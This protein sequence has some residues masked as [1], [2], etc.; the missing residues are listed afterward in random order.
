MESYLIS[1]RLLDFLKKYEDL[2]ITKKQ[3]IAKGVSKVFSDFIYEGFVPDTW[4]IRDMERIDNRELVFHW[5][6]R[7]EQTACPA[8][9]TVSHYQVKIYDTRRI[10]DLPT[11]GMT[12]FHKVKANRYTCENPDCTANMFVEQFADIADKDAR[13][14]HRLKDLGV[15]MAVE[16]SCHGTSKKLEAMGAQVSA[17]TITREVKKKGAAVVA[18]NLKRDDVKVLSVDDINLRKG[19]A[20]TACSVFIDA[21]THRVLVIVQGASAD[22]A[23]KVIQQ[24]PSADTV[25]R[26]RGNAYRAAAT[27]YGKS[28]VADE[29]HLVQN[30]HQAVKEAL[31]LEIGQD[32]FVRKG[33][34]WIQMVDSAQEMP[35]PDSSHQDHDEGLIVIGPATLTEADIE[36]RIRLGCLTYRQAN[37]YKRTMEIL[38]LTESGLRTSEIARRLGMKPLDVSLYRKNAPEIIEKVEHKIDEYEQIR[39]QGQWASHQKTVS[40]NAR[41]SSKSIVEPYKETV[42]RMYQEGNSHRTIHAAIAQ[43]GFEGSPNTVYQYLIRFARENDIPYGR[44]ARIIPDDAQPRPPRISVERVSK[45]A[46]Y[47]SLL[48]AAATEKE[49]WKQGDLPTSKTS[50]SNIQNGSGEWVN[51]TNFPDDVAEIIFDTKVKKEKASK[52]N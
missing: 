3:E 46:I 23:E 41:H 40:P 24:F 1:Q 21:E 13:L 8:C 28:Q 2:D 25:S 12:V 19:N 52:K 32:L 44:N 5:A 39:A 36:R 26:D 9:G 47:E 51:Q 37:K 30:I 15:R 4:H 50:E 10:Q 17:D 20:S 16:S 33:N 34:G 6:S 22:I 11:S 31:S 45:T 43:A 48:R 7:T 14:T 49:K 38:E 42:L 18:E 27:T 29:F 35:T